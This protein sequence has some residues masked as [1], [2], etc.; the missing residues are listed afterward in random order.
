MLVANL[1]PIEFISLHDCSRVDRQDQSN[2]TGSAPSD[3]TQFV[4]RLVEHVHPSVPESTVAALKDTLLRYEHVFSKSD[5][6]LGLTDIISHRIDT[7]AANL[8]RQ[9]LRRFPPAHV[10]AISEHVDSMLAQGVIEPACSPFAS[11]VVLVRKKDGSFR[12]C[13]D[14]R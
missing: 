3:K 8:V 1:Q 11:N 9:Q 13:I 6:D 7:G 14:Y 4:E 12:C 5:T 10:Q 2:C